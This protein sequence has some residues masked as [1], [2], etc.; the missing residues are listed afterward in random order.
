MCWDISLH[1][2][3]DIVKKIFL[4]LR[5]ERKQL[6]YN[7]CYV[8]NVQYIFNSVPC[9]CS[10]ILSKMN[11]PVHHIFNIIVTVMSAFTP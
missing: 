9:S 8:E 11:Y 2:D 5:D 6:D 10:E 3:L 1:T 7:Y 4:K